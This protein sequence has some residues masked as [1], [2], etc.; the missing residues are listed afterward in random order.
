MKKA[1]GSG[2]VTKVATGAMQN[3]DVAEVASSLLPMRLELMFL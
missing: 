3:G 1:M 2:E